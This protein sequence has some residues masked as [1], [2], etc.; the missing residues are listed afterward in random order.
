MAWHAVLVASCTFSLSPG[1]QQLACKVA[2][3]PQSHDPQWPCAV[4]ACCL[5][6]LQL[7]SHPP[8]CTRG[9]LN[10][11]GS[12]V[13]RKSTAATNE[14][15]SLVRGTPAPL[16]TPQQGFMYPRRTSVVQAN[17]RAG[18]Q[19]VVGAVF[20]QGDGLPVQGHLKPPPS[21]TKPPTLFSE[22]MSAGD[23]ATREIRRAAHSE[24]TTA[25]A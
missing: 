22:L 7:I 9:S 15:T 10:Q 5:V 20:T 21:A 8:A 6:H 13:P 11:Q 3:E 19:L 23:E 1:A 18:H 14:R 12:P 17:P 4:C 25:P 2:R 24:V 16:T